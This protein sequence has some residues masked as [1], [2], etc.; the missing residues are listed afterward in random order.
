MSSEPDDLRHRKFPLADRMLTVMVTIIVIDLALVSPMAG[1]VGESRHW[2]DIV[3]SLVLLLGTLV[4]WGNLWLTDLF[5]A[6]SIACVA[7]RL[8]YI[9]W[10]T[11]EWEYAGSALASVNYVILGYL[12]SRRV[13]A[14]GRVNIHRIQG[15]VAVY[16]LA[17]LVLTQVLH[18]V[19][20]A[21]P[22]AFMMLGE[23]ATHER[24]APHLLYYSFVTLTTTG[25]GD[26][27]PVHSLARSFSIVGA[28]FGT[29]FPA[30]LI[31]RLVSLEFMQ[32][33]S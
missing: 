12:L 3:L 20:L 14:P 8:G 26:I 21:S 19:S 4:I 13:F 18:L 23:V 6:T 31:G 17:G 2:A 7:S 9:R 5:V 1:M 30:I 15:A 22:G 29:L 16:L 24:I 11:V 27:V 28:I 33:R 25:F 10:G 32:H